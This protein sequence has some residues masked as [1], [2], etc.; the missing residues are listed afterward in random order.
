MDALGNH[1]AAGM[2]TITKS[3]V[4]NVTDV[5]AALFFEPG[6]LPKSV[7]NLSRCNR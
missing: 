2:Q 6:L 4:S 5:C 1:E 7:A 3:S